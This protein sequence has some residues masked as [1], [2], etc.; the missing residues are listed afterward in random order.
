MILGWV[1]G[2]VSGTGLAAANVYISLTLVN[3]FGTKVAL[4]PA[5]W[6]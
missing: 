2:M 5:W 6:R 3:L 4:M 1:G